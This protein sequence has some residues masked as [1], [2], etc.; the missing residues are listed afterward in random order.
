[1][2]QELALSI[3]SKIMSWPDDEARREFAW[4]RVMARLKYD[5]YQDFLAGVRFLESLVKWLQQFDATER[6][7]AYRFVR[8]SLVYVG[9]PEME[10]LVE[11]FYP[12]TV[13]NDFV[14]R[15]ATQMSIPKYRIWSHP[16]GTARFARVRRKTLYMGLS[17]GARIDILRHAHVG[18]I[19]NEQVALTTQLDS[20]KWHDLLQKLR[21]DLGDP[22]AR[23]AGVYLIDDFMGTGT[24]FL[25]F[26]T[27]KNPWT[28]KLMRFRDSVQRAT[29]DLD[30]ISPFEPDW[31]LRAH[32]YLASYDAAEGVRDRIAQVKSLLKSEI[33]CADVRVS[34]GL[35][36][37]KSL[38]I[39]TGGHNDFIA[40]TQKYYDPVL[41]TEHTDV[42]GA[43]HVGLGYGAC[44][45]PLVLFHNTPNN[46]VALL[47]AET[48]GGP[49]DDGTKAPAM[50]PLF[51]RRQRHA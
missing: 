12:R 34:F 11:A 10:R 4:L 46:S 7:T 18:A 21:R 19:S 22:E 14:Q 29:K 50:R 26:S 8:N 31:E 17:D 3:L 25:R 20:D 49:L 40:L 6:Q 39:T 24:S 9:Q 16:D 30:G 15:V 41:R 45:L 23:F 48:N 36:L 5:G 32:H 1:L 47:W 43:T 42:G 27:D 2:N 13:R 33:G 35:I 44:A 51:R 38:P 28:G 37:P